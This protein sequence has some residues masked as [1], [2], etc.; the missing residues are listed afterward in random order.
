MRILAWI[1]E[2]KVGLPV[3]GCSGWVPV[4]TCFFFFF[5]FFF[6]VVVVVVVLFVIFLLPVRLLVAV[7]LAFPL[8]RRFWGFVLPGCV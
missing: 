8:I 2:R 1:I 3:K 5:F 7:A 4:A 6:L